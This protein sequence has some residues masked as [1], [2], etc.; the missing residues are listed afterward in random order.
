MVDL[1]S[2]SLLVKLGQI[3]DLTEQLP[4]EIPSNLQ[5]NFPCFFSVYY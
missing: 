2:S 1:A 5:R 4:L 3:M